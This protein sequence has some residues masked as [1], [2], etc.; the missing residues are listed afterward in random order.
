MRVERDLEQPFESCARELVDIHERLLE[1]RRISGEC[2]AEPEIARL[3]QRRSELVE[4]LE[5]L[6]ILRRSAA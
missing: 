5:A 6:A 1:M 2:A 4:R 3:L